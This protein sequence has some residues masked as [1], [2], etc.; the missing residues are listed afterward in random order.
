M[1]TDTM[2]RASEDLFHF[3][4]VFASIFVGFALLGHLLFG[5]DLI[6]FST[7]IKSVNTAYECLLGDFGWYV[8]RVISDV[9][10]GSGMPFFVIVIWF[11]SFTFIVVLVM[12]NML[13]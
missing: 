6:E 3:T 11:Y 2:I 8:E 7:Y 5:E 13:L 9:P 12:M 4:V 1:V 10:L